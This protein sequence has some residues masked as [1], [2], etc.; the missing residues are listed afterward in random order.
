[1]TSIQVSIVCYTCNHEKY[2]KDAIESFLMQKTN[3]TYEIIIYVDASK[4]STQAIVK[5]YE[6]K[7]PTLITAVYQCEK[8][9]SKFVDVEYEMVQRAQGKYI[10][11]CEGDGFWTD[12]YKLQKQYEFMEEH[13]TYSLCVHAG[14]VVRNNDKKTIAYRKPSS[15][16]KVYTTEEIIEGGK[17]YFLTNTMFFRKQLLD[18]RAD[19]V[20]GAALSD[21][22]LAVYLSL[23]GEV[24]YIADSMASYR[25]NVK[26]SWTSKD[27]VNGQGYRSKFEEITKMLD[28]VNEYTNYR[29]AEAIE[30]RK[31]SNEVIVLVKERNF[32]KLRSSN[33]KEAERK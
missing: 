28:E 25:T 31:D 30:R 16:A 32:Q 19:F 27:S 10:A 24:Y 21:Y 15:V 9:S 20:A 6:N 23:V 2:I 26:G 4:D 11:F 33:L 18:N 13:L 7:Y 22:P 8:Q 14:E 3:F 17:G 1:M 12:S 29:F 5:E